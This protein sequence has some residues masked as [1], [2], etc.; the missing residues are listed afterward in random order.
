MIR[1]QN[2]KMIRRLAFRIFK[3]NRMRNVIAI[4]AIAMTTVLFTCL[5]TTMIGMVE[6]LQNQTLRQAG[7]DG[8]AVL[9]YI[10]DEQYNA[11]KDH[12]LIDEI[13]YNLIAA[14]H[15]DNSAFL[16]R[17]LEMYYM[18]ETAMK[19]GF[20]VPTTGKAP[21]AQNEIITDTVTLD[22]LGV[23]HEVGAKVPLMYTMKGEQM[24]T[25]FV[26]SGYWETDPVAPVGMAVV[27]KEFVQA[28][29]SE[30]R[31][32]NLVDH[33]TT[34]SINAYILFKNSFSLENKLNQVITES[35]YTMQS[36]NNADPLPTDIAANVNWA[37]L[38]SNF[39]LA[40]PI[41]LIA[42]VAVILLIT[43][44]GYLMINNLFQISVNKD[45]RDYG[46]LKTIGTTRRQMKFII[47]QQALLLSIVGIPL[48]LV[49][50]LIVG[51]SL[52]EL[53][54]GILTYVG[55]VNISVHPL[56]FM[57]AT[58]FTFVTVW[59]STRK[60][61]K[62]AAAVSP[63]EAVRYQGGRESFKRKK[64]KST[65]G[66]KIWRMAWSNLGRSKKQT[67]M[68]LISMSLS[69]VLLSTVFTLSR[70]FDMDKFVS[71]FVNM[72]YLIGHANYFNDNRFRQPEDELSES[73][74]K[75]VQEQEGFQE[76]GKIYYNIYLGQSSI[77][78]ENPDELNSHGH[79]MNKAEDGNPTLDLYGL[80]DLPLKRLDIVEGKLDT[81]KLKSGKYIIEGVHQDDEG[82]VEWNTSHYQIGDTVQITVDGK[83]YEYEVMAK[84]KIN[85][86]TIGNRSYDE[87]A[88]YL[89][90]E[91]YL[92]VVTRPVLMT[93][94]FNMADDQES[95][96]ETFI[97]NYTETIEPLMNYES[98][99]VYVNNFKKFQNMVIIVGSAIS[100]VIGLI[101]ILNFINS[102]LTSILSRRL[103]FAMLQSIGMTG[104]QLK[105]MLLYEGGYYAGAT[106]VLSLI[107]STL[108]STFI[109]RGL[110]SNLWFFSY[111]FV[112]SPLLITYPILFL[113]FVIVPYLAYRNIR[114]QTIVER[115]RIAE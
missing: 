102:I 113:L 7:G 30:L 17:R 111:Q 108:F 52:L 6:N 2:R 49:I 78:R 22:L 77:T 95:A 71:K 112:L 12:P 27:S 82:R 59:I 74:I 94:G 88:M 106:I 75:A 99:Q 3:A 25:D 18:D 16:K 66:G 115:L 68:M 97:K 89:P 85:Q 35:G 40:D 61:G 31:H 1:V 90:T 5:F 37:Y 43:F 67:V 83:K 46:L 15:V 63:V 86:F 42:I 11:V 10:T 92:K 65:D 114:R 20:T 41:S 21:Q 110:V 28:H 51:N 53:M 24:Q 62:M 104:R 14:D 56:I 19:L 81:A 33:N 100:F 96:M 48:G 47:R 80:D 64:K 73:F 32:T 84:A 103:E 105:R 29:A 76:G 98:K 54:L 55:P 44:T 38:S 9:K 72:D 101:G 58:I 60:P 91:E 26:L 8:H 69:L 34:G 36:E 107:L 87:F 79:P 70:G 39:P 57:G 93:Y 13:S 45:I 4:I 23:P 50:G 109:V